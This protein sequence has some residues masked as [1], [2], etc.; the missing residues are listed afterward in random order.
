MQLESDPAIDFRDIVRN[1]TRRLDAQPVMVMTILRL[2]DKYIGLT[3]FLGGHFG[4]L[5]NL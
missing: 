5:K 3:T 2:G 4:A 1:E